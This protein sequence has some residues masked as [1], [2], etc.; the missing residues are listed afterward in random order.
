MSVLIRKKLVEVFTGQAGNKNDRV[1]LNSYANTVVANLN[2]VRNFKP[3]QL[4]QF[5]NIL[6]RLC[7]NY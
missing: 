1:A 3:F 2:A 5:W 7:V 4:F 6:Y